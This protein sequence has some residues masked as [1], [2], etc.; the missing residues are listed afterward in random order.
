MNF[1]NLFYATIKPDCDN[2]KCYAFYAGKE[3]IVQSVDDRED[4]YMQAVDFKQDFELANG[5][6]ATFATADLENIKPVLGIQ[7]TIDISRNKTLCKDLHNRSCHAWFK[8]DKSMTF[9]SYDEQSMKVS[10]NVAIAKIVYDTFKAPAR[11]SVIVA[12]SAIKRAV[13]YTYQTKRNMYRI[14]ASID[15]LESSLQRYESEFGLDYD[16]DYQRGYVWTKEQQQAY[17]EYLLSGGIS[18]REI[19]FNYPAWQRWSIKDGRMEI[20]DGKQRL[21]ALLSFLRGEVLAFGIL[22]YTDLTRLDMENLDIYININELVNKEDIVKW[23]LSM[24]T[25]GSVH[26]ENDLQVAKNV[27]KQL[28]NDNK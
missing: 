12:M 21:N 2:A 20:V 23:Y 25:G 14:V 18:G 1:N 6:F 24:N 4:I 15:Y 5:N 17:I 11:E 16:P 13:D 9:E 28:Q 22:R 27:L 8:R 3:V 10:V 26:T 19:Y 7:F